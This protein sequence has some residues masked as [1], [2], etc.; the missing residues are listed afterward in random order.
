MVFASC[1]FLDK[2]WQWCFTHP[3]SHMT[4]W[5]RYCFEV[6]IHIWMLT[7]VFREVN[8]FYWCAWIEKK[9]KQRKKKFCLFCFVVLF[10]WSLLWLIIMILRFVFLFI[11]N[12]ENLNLFLFSNREIIEGCLYLA[13]IRDIAVHNQN[14]IALGCKI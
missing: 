7:Y 2:C 8:D 6:L 3:S 9:K 5:L 12:H 4:V 10:F 1:P 13:A 14:L 11:Q